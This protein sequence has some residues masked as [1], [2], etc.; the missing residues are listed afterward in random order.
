MNEGTVDVEGRLCWALVLYDIDTMEHGERVGRL[1]GAIAL[2]AGWALERAARLARAARLHDIGK[3][4]TPCALLR[5]PTQLTPEEYAEVQRHAADG[6]AIAARVVAD[7]LL[8]EVAHAHHERW[9][10]LGYPR[11][12]IGT[13]IPL[14]A[15]IVAVAD[16]YDALRTERPYKLAWSHEEALAYV[17]ANSGS[18]FD[19]EVV[20]AFLQLVELEAPSQPLS[21]RTDPHEHPTQPHRLL[22]RRRPGRV[23]GAPR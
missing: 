19:P 18:H 2:Q 15:R 10:G 14:A 13:A 23:A 4:D 5:K 22:C 3:L 1:A 16:V 17:I 7:E 21:E 8:E 11:R 20:A 12:L 9:D 6:A